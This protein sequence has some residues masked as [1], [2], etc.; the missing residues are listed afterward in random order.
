MRMGS[1]TPGLAHG[2][3]FPRTQIAFCLGSKRRFPRKTALPAAALFS[4]NMLVGTRPIAIAS[5]NM[6]L[7]GYEMQDSLMFAACA[8]PDPP[9]SSNARAI[10][11][12]VKRKP[13]TGKIGDEF[14]VEAEMEGTNAKQLNRTLLSATRRPLSGSGFEVGLRQTVMNPAGSLDRAALFG[15]IWLAHSLIVEEISPT[16]VQ[17]FV[18]RGTQCN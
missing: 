9:G 17:R 12:A 16:A 14:I 3:H 6:R 15:M 7:G 10:Q 4:L 18:A 8:C 13:S 5:R 11:Q 1:L 2:P